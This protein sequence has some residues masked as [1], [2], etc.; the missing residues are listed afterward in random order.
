MA[1]H[2]SEAL[3]FIHSFKLVHRDVKRQINIQIYLS[4]TERV[5]FSSS[6]V[7]LGKDEKSLLIAKLADFGLS[8]YLR[9]DEAGSFYTSTCVGTKCYMPPEAFRGRV[10]SA[11]DVYA[12]GMVSK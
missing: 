6:N 1:L 8:S 11:G 5:Y 4:T 10:S 3:N 7:L 12:F 2:I 9:E